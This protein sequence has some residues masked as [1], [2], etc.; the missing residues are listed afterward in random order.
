MNNN[1][2]ILINIEV[3]NVAERIGNLLGLRKNST[4]KDQDAVLDLLIEGNNALLNVLTQSQN[5]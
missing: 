3:V 1:Q 4:D 2:K 5:Q